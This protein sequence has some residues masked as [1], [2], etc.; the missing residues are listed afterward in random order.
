MKSPTTGE[1]I[2]NHEYHNG[3]EW[4]RLTSSTRFKLFAENPIAYRYPLP[5]DGSAVLDAGTATHTTILEPDKITDMIVLPDIGFR[6]NADKASWSQ[7]LHDF[8]A[9][10][11]AIAK[12]STKD[13]IINLARETAA[14][15]G[16]AICSH[17]Q[18]EAAAAMALSVHEHDLARESLEGADKELSF[19]AY[20][21]KARPDAMLGSLLTDLKT[22]GQVDR[23]KWQV[24]DLKYALSLAFYQSVLADC[25]RHVDTWS[26]IVVESKPFR[27]GPDGI[28][29]HRAQ[30]YTAG[31][32]MM[33][34]GLHQ[35]MDY[36]S[37]LRECNRSGKWENKQLPLIT[38][39]TL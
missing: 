38:L 17:E 27:L 36:T 7:W 30:V 20:E 25:G 6:S 34:E 33:N 1:V 26:W 2:S 28:P 37:R 18:R 12:I 24:K 19:R 23:F 16:Q 4:G 13:T 21:R 22:T 14:K 31:D 29:R 10:K 11:D 9:D 8:G 35:V 39:E 3:Q 5:M 32:D 15:Q